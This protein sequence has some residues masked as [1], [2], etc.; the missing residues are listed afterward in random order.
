[1]SD[2]QKQFYIA[3]NNADYHGIALALSNGVKLNNTNGRNNTLN[4]A[5]RTILHKPI[6]E[7]NLKFIEVLLE[8]G[9]KMC[10]NNFVNHQYNIMVVIICHGKQYLERALIENN[11]EAG[12]KNIMDL[13][14]LVLESEGYDFDSL[15]LGREIIAN[16]SNFRDLIMGASDM[17]PSLIL[18]TGIKTCELLVVKTL[19]EQFKIKPNASHVKAAIMLSKQHCVDI[20]NHIGFIETLYGYGGLSESV[21]MMNPTLTETLDQ[22]LNIG[23]DSGDYEVVKLLCG[24]GVK[25][26]RSQTN[27]NTLS[28]AVRTKSTKIIKLVLEYNGVPDQSQ[29]DSILSENTLSLAVKTKDSEIVRMIC[30]S[31]ALP[32]TTLSN[33]TLYLAMFTMDPFMGGIPTD[34]TEYVT[35]DTFTYNKSMFREIRAHELPVEK[36]SKF[37]EILN[38]LM[39]AGARIYPDTIDVKHYHGYIWQRLREYYYFIN[40]K[41]ENAREYI[42]LRE[43]IRTDLITTMDKLI[44]DYEPARRYIVDQ[45]DSV[46]QRCIPVPCIEIISG[47]VRPFKYI[48]WSKY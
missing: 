19:C 23:I 27:D 11:Y 20:D 39:C 2:W 28:C 3:L 4:S 40:N 31:G 9:A 48:D 33:N 29:S 47:Y 1:M 41:D 26:N 38:L 37:D 43:K 45:I 17:A 22:I 7:F 5:I 8:H 24:Y 35:R 6:N 15:V 16:E 30:E 14:K 44:K 36:K 34:C 32:N 42:G 13:L 21:N 46:T 18:M 25:I 12:R 10:M